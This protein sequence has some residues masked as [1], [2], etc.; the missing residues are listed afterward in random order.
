MTALEVSPEPG[1]RVRGGPAASTTRIYAVANQKG[2]VGKTTTA[3][4]AELLAG[5]DRV[6]IV[7]TGWVDRMQAARVYAYRLAEESFAPDEEVGGYWLS[8][9]TVLPIDVVQLDDLVERH[10]SAAIELRTLDNLWPMWSRVV[11][12]SL[13]FS[14]IRLHNALP[15]PA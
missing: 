3:D 2:G 6:H 1:I 11:G 12:S 14:G 13:E 15:V 8:R 4:D 5:S 10:R 7:E 9:D